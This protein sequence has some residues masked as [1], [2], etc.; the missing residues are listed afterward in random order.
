VVERGR[1][2]RHRDALTSH[3][4][5][6]VALT[7]AGTGAEYSTGEQFQYAYDGVGNRTVHT[8]TFVS[9]LSSVWQLLAGF[10]VFPA[11]PAHFIAPIFH[12]VAN[13]FHVF[14]VL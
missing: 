10:E 13:Q 3:H 4:A 12:P 11:S 7:E 8:Q 6:V 14:Y 1:L 9:H 5:D 2:G